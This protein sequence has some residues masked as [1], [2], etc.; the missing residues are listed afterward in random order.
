MSELNIVKK[1]ISELKA[2]K[3]NPRINMYA[4]PQVK[5]SIEKYGYKVPIVIDRNNEIVCG[6]TR[7][8]A[9][10]ELNY[11]TI[12]CLLADDLNEQQIKEFRIIDNKTQEFVQWDFPKLE[13]E[14]QGLDLNLEDLQVKSFYKTEKKEDYNLKEVNTHELKATS[15]NIKKGD[16]YKLG[17]HYL[18]C[19][20]SLNEQDID[21]LIGKGKKPSLVILDPPYGMKKSD[22]KNDEIRTFELQDFLYKINDLLLKKVKESASFF[23][24]NNFAPLA[25]FYT[26]Y[27]DKAEREGKLTFRNFITWNKKNGQNSN[28]QQAKSFANYCEYILFYVE[29]NNGFFKFEN[30]EKSN[31]YD[32]WLP[33]LEYMQKEK[34]ASGLREKTWEREI[35]KNT[36]YGHYF[37]RTQFELIP[38]NNYKKLQEYYPGHFLKPW[39]LLKL[40]YDEIE[41]ERIQKEAY[42][43]SIFYGGGG[44]VFEHV[45]ARMTD[46]GKEHRT[47]VFHQ[48]PKPIEQIKIL[49]GTTTDLV[50]YNYVLDPFG[51]S[52]TTLL[53]CEQMKRRCY[54]MELDP[55]HCQTIIN[56]WEDLTKKKAEKVNG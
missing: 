16:I 33:I 45:N 44:N 1:K 35:I 12:D 41:K 38:Q 2:Y 20:D 43:N 27:I 9:L 23:L 32:G 40:E 24:Y 36:A 18:M 56:R 42:F 22:V 21:L 50:N 6:H 25:M 30:K 11:E 55:L 53:A 19:G 28:S 17:D 8:L 39:V 34:E 47:N 13:L 29:G 26:N 3:N 46:Y 54:I 15:T 7:F 49:I 10:K 51:G 4:V 52:G 5:K 37:T 48:T 31:F 14:L